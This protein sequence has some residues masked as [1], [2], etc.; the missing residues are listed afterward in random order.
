MD[1]AKDRGHTECV[2]LLEKAEADTRG[3]EAAEAAEAAAEVRKA[4]DEATSQVVYNWHNALR[5]ITTMYKCRELD[6][7]PW[8]ACLLL[9]TSC[10]YLHCFDPNP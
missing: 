2:A 9:V 3:G 4:L 1:I 8:P 5:T 10:Y 6:M 7:S